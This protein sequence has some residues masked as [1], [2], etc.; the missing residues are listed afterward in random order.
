VKSAR[1]LVKTFVGCGLVCNAA[2]PARAFD[3]FGLFGAPEK[4]SPSA[5]AVAYDMEIKGVEDSKLE[6][7]LQDAS[8]S[9]RLRLESPSAGAGLARR[10]VADYPRLTEALWANGYFNATIRASVAGV[11]VSPD[12]AGA[13][14]AGVAAERLRGSALASVVFDIDPGP[15]FKLRHVVVYDARTNAPIDPALFPKRPSTPIPTTRPARRRCARVRRN[16]STN[17]GTNPTRSP[18]SSRRA[19]SSCTRSR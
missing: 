15:L 9:W 4:A 16:G 13:E 10:V 17:C 2:S 6:Q 19:P 7:T 5:D 11:P 14:A 18:K 3:F 1:F 12:G 8:N